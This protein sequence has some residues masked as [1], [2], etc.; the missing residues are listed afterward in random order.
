MFAEP[1]GRTPATSL[2]VWLLIGSLC[3][4]AV[5]VSAFL[6]QAFEGPFGKVQLTWRRPQQISYLLH[7]AGSDDLSPELT[8]Q[9][10]RES[11][12]VWA[13]VPT[14]RVRFIDQGVTK[15]RLPSGR[16]RQNLVFF[17]ET[18][19]YLQVPRNSG[20]IALTR[21]SSN[22]LTG[23][24]LDADIIFNG[25]DFRFAAGSERPFGS[26]DL[27]DVAIHEIG[28]LLGLEHT[29]L[30]GPPEIRPTMNPFNWGDGP[31]EGQTLEAD[32]IAGISVLYPA[33]GY[34]AAT[35]T[36]SGQVADL[37]DNP[38][39]GAHVIAEN[40]DTGE[41][42]STLSGAA[43]K[44]PDRGHYTLRGLTPGLYRLLLSPIEGAISEENFGG[45]FTDF[46]T[47]FPKEYYDNART[48]DLARTIPL[49]GGQSVD[50]TD[51]TT[52]FSHPDFP[53]L[54]AVTQFA[55]TPDTRGPYS[56]QVQ[57]T[58]AA[59]IYLR[60]RSETGESSTQ[61]QPTNPGFFVA[62]I[63]GQPAGTQVFYQIEARSARGNATFFPH[64]EQWLS[65]DV[66]QL[67]GAP[68]AFTAFRGD[69]VV[70][71]FDT[72]ARRELA[73]IQVGDEP[74]QVL[75]AWADDRLF[76]SNLS[77]NEIL[78]IDTAT[79]QIVDRVQTAT[80]PLDMALSPDGQT[81]YVTNS[82]AGTLTLIDVAS[83]TSR[84]VRLPLIG[85]GPYGVAATGERIY[86]TDIS[87]DQVLV[88]SPDGSI[89]HRLPVPP[90]PRSL[91][92]SPDATKLYVTS[93]GSNLLTVIDV[94]NNQVTR[95]I[96]L[97]VS[98]TFAVAPSPD[99]SKVYLTAHN[100]GELIVVDA[101]QDTV[102]KTLSIG[103]NPRAISFSPDGTQAFVTS[104]FSNEVTI[105]N[106][107]TDAV[108]STYA[109]GQNPRGIALDLPSMSG[110]ETAVNEAAVTP[111]AFSLHPNYPNPF[112]ASTQI[113][114]VVP[115]VPNRQTVVELKIYNLLGQQV[116]TLVRQ[117]QDAGIYRVEWD[118]RNEMG[119]D[120]ASGVYVLI[121]RAAADRAVQ[122]MLLLR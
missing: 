44:A 35:G 104:S 95:T 11:F 39:F 48:P 111:D 17:D 59:Q 22:D 60:Y 12:A 51:F 101:R 83:G 3:V 31:G 21:V 9:L 93:M 99:G 89:E 41:F 68:L 23:E 76:V 72:G 66:V 63:P 16:D 49:S 61:M 100:E 98:G 1:P 27:K 57:A 121:L 64:Q 14:A 84:I 75:L 86:T 70:S 118:G 8:H 2:P 47:D 53:F 103:A 114:Y 62:R 46:A 80:Q 6:I 69:D 5:P 112:N 32:D 55:N 79:F 52:G 105:L 102:L 94:G 43:P 115:E 90:Q 116:R 7:S 91:A 108:L 42:F 58:N 73:R 37:D 110:S 106:T 71:V 74:I 87:A 25:R 29:P 120:L 65:F 117:R 107:R 77:S 13:A 113:T 30:E 109:V 82:G 85:S 24:I 54:R 67:T 34:L 26:V 45:I 88:I 20:V 15:S 10:L 78:V 33:T 56:V 97:P 96:P 36:I 4:L 18:G 122:K 119:N 38:L 81:L 19:N 92:L 50:E 28:H 40:L